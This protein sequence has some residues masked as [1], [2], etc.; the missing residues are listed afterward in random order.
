MKTLLMLIV[1]ICLELVLWLV[2]YFTLM[3]KNLKLR[4]NWTFILR[5]RVVRTLTIGDTK[6]VSERKNKINTAE[7]KDAVDNTVTTANR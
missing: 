6:N 7:D 3:N 1:A 5:A 4:D 2:K